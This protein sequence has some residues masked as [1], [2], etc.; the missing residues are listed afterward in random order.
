VVKSYETVKRLKQ[1]LSSRGMLQP[2]MLPLTNVT[3]FTP[4]GRGGELLHRCSI[5]VAHRTLYASTSRAAAVCKHMHRHACPTPTRPHT[6]LPLPAG[7]VAM[8]KRSP[9]AEQLLHEASAGS[10]PP[11]P[12]PLPHTRTLC[13]Q[14]RQT[15]LA[16]DEWP[17]GC[18]GYAVNLVRPV[19][20]GQRGTVLHSQIGRGLVFE[21]MDSAAAYKELCTQVG[22][23]WG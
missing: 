17:A 22:V 9:L 4:D 20:K 16:A 23:G 8:R 1:S 12:I 5:A 7:D 11:L 19:V 15:P 10:D 18:L 6:P 21:T 3:P 2:S 14:Q 13:G